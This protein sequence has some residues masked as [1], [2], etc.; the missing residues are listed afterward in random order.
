M[1]GGAT[2]AV[3]YRLCRKE[4]RL[5]HAAE[6]RAEAEARAKEEL[7]ASL[8]FQRIALAHR[9]LLEDNLLQAEELLDQCPADRR[10]WEWYYLKRLCHV[11]PVTVR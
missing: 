1:A 10:A 11:E 9:E 2:A 6:D 4:E 8:Y 5:R 3:Q 7:E